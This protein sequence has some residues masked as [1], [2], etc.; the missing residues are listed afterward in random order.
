MASSEMGRRF[1]RKSRHEVNSAAGNRSGGRKKR[2]TSS[3]SSRT[4]GKFGNQTEQQSADDEQDGIG[5][6]QLA[7]EQRQHGHRQQIRQRFQ[8]R[9]S[10]RLKVNC[11]RAV[12]TTRLLLHK[13]KTTRLRNTG[14]T[15][16]RHEEANVSGAVKST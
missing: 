16:P 13:A 14:Q 11:G 4:F 2:K 1:A 3:G 6:V 8:Q 12:C 10:C 5:D 7:G 15:K 9:P